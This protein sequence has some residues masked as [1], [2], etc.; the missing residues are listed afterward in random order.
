MTGLAPLERGKADMNAMQSRRTDEHRWLVS[1]VST[2]P[3]SPNRHETKH[4][5]VQNVGTV[6]MIKT[7]LFR[8]DLGSNQHTK[9]VLAYKYLAIIRARQTKCLLGC[10]C[11]PVNCTFLPVL[12][13][14][15]IA[16][17]FLILNFLPTD[18]CVI[19]LLYSNYCK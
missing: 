5:N 12:W 8:N 15:H 14:V 19:K 2:S 9:I 10:L 3:V 11:F 4:C 13:H 7:T 18:L 6:G 16:L 17:S 1:C